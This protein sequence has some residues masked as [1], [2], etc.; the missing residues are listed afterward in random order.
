M[1]S[2]DTSVRTRN[3]V[4]FR[5]SIIHLVVPHYRPLALVEPV[6]RSNQNP[7]LKL[8]TVKQQHLHDQLIYQQPQQHNMLNK[9][10]KLHKLLHWKKKSNNQCKFFSILVFIE[11]LIEILVQLLISN[12]RNFNRSGRKGTLQ[13]WQFLVALLD[14]PGNS[15]FITWTGRGLEFKLLD[16]EEVAR[17]WGKMKVNIYPV[18]DQ[19]STDG[20]RS[21][22]LPFWHLFYSFIQNRPAMNYDKLSRSLRYYYEKGIMSKGMYSYSKNHHFSN[23]F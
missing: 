16:P 15:N 18:L 11:I 20:Q 12:S 14:D 1:I 7:V 3:T 8:S 19:R 9:Q 23:I 5:N 10:H 22:D 2:R 13:L 21:T 4:Q 6:I 17:R